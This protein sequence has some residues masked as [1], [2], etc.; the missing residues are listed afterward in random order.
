MVEEAYPL[1]ITLET[2]PLPST[3]QALDEVGL[4]SVIK[5]PFDVKL[6]CIQ[7]FVRMFAF[8]S[9][10][11]VLA[12]YLEELGYADQSIGLFMTLTML[13]D[14]LISLLLTLFADGLGRKNVLVAGSLLVVLS[15]IVFATTSSYWA[16]LAAAIVGVVSP[17]YVL[18]HYH[19]QGGDN[20]DSTRAAALPSD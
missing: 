20:S 7:R 12:L 3:Q 15:G 19:M 8:G 9:A 2:M 4:T 10:A 11:L 17:R 5:S 6:L 18:E 13:G 16:L 14:V 1:V